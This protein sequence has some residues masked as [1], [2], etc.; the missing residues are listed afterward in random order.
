MKLGTAQSDGL[1]TRLAWVTA[2]RLGFLMLLL[3]ALAT[4]Y[5]RGGLEDYPHTM[6]IVFLTIG[7]SFALGAAYGVALRRGKDLARLAIAQIVCDQLT[8]TAIV[9]VSGGAT[10]GA[11]S[12]YALTCLL[13]AILA[14]E[15]GAAVAAAVGASLYG[16]MCAAFAL[17]WILPPSDQGA[18]N[19]TTEVRELIYPLLV[20]LLGIAVVALL[21]GYLAVRLRLTG[22]ALEDA[23]RRA[24][25]AERLAVLGTLATG[26]A[27]EIRNPLGSI[28]GSIE[29]L[30]ESPALSAEDKQ[31][32]GIV[33]REAARLNNLVTDMMD[34]AKPRSPNPESVDVAALAREVVELAARSD[35]SGAGDVTVS[36]EGPQQATLAR[37]DGAQMRQV[38][39]NLV[40]NAVQAS[41]AGSQVTV[42]VVPGPKTVALSVQD[43]GPGLPEEARARI[44]DAFY[45]TRSHGVGIGLAVV[46]RIIDDHAPFGARIDVAS[47]DGGGAR[48]T[49]ELSTVLTRRLP[50]AP[51]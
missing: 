8:W 32:C 42:R 19:Y 30:R 44:F 13:G 23:Q 28:S 9:Y 35:R 48:F 49:V 4:S 11:T 40:R 33:R 50:L 36:Y 47:P 14:G 3:G 18:A 12:F 15:R 16:V 29:M 21:A 2:L 1:A 10:S 24:L 51:R 45:T 39:W 22:G 5:L 25:E 7:A 20:N 26:L 43:R 31:L 27:H 41:G 17:H 46:K 38:L 37:C 34:Y 6:R